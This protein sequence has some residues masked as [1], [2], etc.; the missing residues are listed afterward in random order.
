M[1]SVG[2]TASFVMSVAVDVLFVLFSPE[3]EKL[4]VPGWDYQNIMGTTELAEDYIFVTSNH[5]HAAADAIWLV[6]RYEPAQYLVQFYKVEPGDKVGVITVVCEPLDAHK[7]RVTVAY[8]YTALTASG[9]AFVASFDAETYRAF[10]GE[11]ETL[12]VAHFE[13]AQEA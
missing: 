4:W 8:Q 12:L 10:I 3:G 11:W 5:D 7:T 2:H 13:G 1:K 6:K 9:E